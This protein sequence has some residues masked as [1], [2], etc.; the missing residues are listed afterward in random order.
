MIVLAINAGSSS[1]KYQLYQM[2]QASVLARGI[3]E[4]ISEQGSKLTHHCDGKAHVVE[5]KVEN[6]EQA[7]DIILKTLVSRDIGVIE[8]ISEIGAVGHRVAHGGEEFT[9]SVVIDDKV[10]ASVEKYADLAQLHT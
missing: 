8:S 6:H 4:R 7:M 5:T 9:G 1:I 2:P 3:V 10:I